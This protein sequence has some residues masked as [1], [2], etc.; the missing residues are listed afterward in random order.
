MPLL[1]SWNP[2]IIPTHVNTYSTMCMLQYK[3]ALARRI[4]CSVADLNIKVTVTPR[5]SLKVTPVLFT[6]VL[7]TPRRRPCQPTDVTTRHS[8]VY[9]LLKAPGLNLMCVHMHSACLTIHCGTCIPLC[10]GIITRSTQS[11]T[12]EANS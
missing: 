9:Q 1:S 12:R 10:A 11:T 6:A 7:R 2:F 4:N 5:C 8:G 3:A